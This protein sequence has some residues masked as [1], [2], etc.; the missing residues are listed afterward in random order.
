MA[1]KTLPPHLGQSG[2]GTGGRNLER[3]REICALKATG[4]SNQAIGKQFNLNRERVRQVLQQAKWDAAAG[5]ARWMSTAER[6]AEAAKERAG[7]A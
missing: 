3:D 5:R 1:R 4:M 2:P 6:R 7:Q